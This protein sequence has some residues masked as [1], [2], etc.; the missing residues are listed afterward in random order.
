MTVAL[1]SLSN[2]GAHYARNFRDVFS[3]MI[4][5]EV[6]TYTCKACNEP[7]CFSLGGKEWHKRS[8][9]NSVVRIGLWKECECPLCL[10]SQANFI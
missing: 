3:N 6:F 9:D 7:E 1:P 10:Y 8:E 5:L 4:L 2:M